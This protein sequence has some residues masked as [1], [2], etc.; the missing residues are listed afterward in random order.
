MLGDQI[1]FK[2][3]VESKDLVALEDKDLSLSVRM[4]E[5][6]YSGFAIQQDSEYTCMVI[7]LGGLGAADFDTEYNI[8]VID[9]LTRK[10]GTLT[11][12]VNTYIARMF[13]G[14]EGEADN[15]LRAIYALGVAA[16]A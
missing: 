7:L 14:G 3:G 16:N 6:D 9:G 8:T 4:G 5:E 1:A 11:Y 12:S 10:S 2:I 15:L 13:E